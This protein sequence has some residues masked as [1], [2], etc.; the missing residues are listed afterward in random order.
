MASTRLETVITKKEH[1]FIPFI[2]AGDPSPELTIELALLMEEAGAHILELGVPYSDPL[3][4]GPVIQQAALRA[5]EYKVNLE[6][7]MSLVPMMRRRGL[8]I[9]VIIFTYYNPVLQLGEENVLAL[10]KENE[11]DGILIPDLP[12]E[13]SRHL[14]L[15]C[16][17][18]G[19]PLISLVAPT[20]EK[21]VEMIAK[22]AKG[23][24][25]C[26]SSL[27]VTGVRKEI[28]EGIFQFL[29]E[30][31]K[32]SKVPVAVGFGISNSE[33]VAKL[34]P[35]CDGLIVGSALIKMIE[36]KKT[37]MLDNKM[38]EKALSEIKTFV[39]SLISS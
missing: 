20:S 9:P 26:V 28:D 12:F 27:G 33:Q 25:Y 36:S 24:L 13:E 6:Q 3:A 8:T 23:F 10:M 32:H 11:I 31:K 7:V 18:E 14:S 19:L 22:Q 17:Q 16:D 37:E 30:V 29:E 2:M 38:R 34:K 5:L 15:R 39:Y 35:Y 1:L 4:D 21:R